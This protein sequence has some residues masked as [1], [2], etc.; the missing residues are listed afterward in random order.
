MAKNNNTNLR[1]PYL[2]NLEPYWDA[3]ID[4]KTGLPYKMISGVG[5]QLQSGILKNLRILD[6]TQRINLFKWS[7]LPS[8]MNGNLIE[9][10]LYY[11]GQAA[12]WYNDIDDQYYFLPFALNGSIDVYGRY[13]GITPLPFNG[14]AKDKEDAWIVGLN[15]VPQY[16]IENINNNDNNNLKTT[17]CVILRDYS[18]QISQTVLPR[19]TLSEP[20]LNLMSEAIPFA[21]T[22][23]LSN[24][25]MKAMRVNDETDANEVYQ[26]SNSIVDHA[27]AGSPFIPIKSPIEFQE[28]TSS[29]SAMKSEEYLLYYQAL[30]NLRKSFL[31]I[32]N[33]GVFEKQS[34]TLQ[35]EQDMN[36]N[37]N[38][39]IMDDALQLRKEFC[40]MVN[41]IWG[42][43]INVELNQEA[44]EDNNNYG[45]DEDDEDGG[46]D[47]NG[48]IENRK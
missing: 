3:G 13:L 42:L 23:L 28:L 39:L 18:Q 12:F 26:A 2:P 7:N 41:K 32:E 1:T 46:T 15:R 11:K 9:R 22:S 36:S 31:G 47:S 34:H 20:L 14:T 44:L 40:E 24:S 38:N 45:T 48:S 33:G 30:D 16:D 27:L 8:S 19:A 4:P 29:G 25:G 43:N 10:I 17:A 35:S 6:E 21:R 5:C 37:S